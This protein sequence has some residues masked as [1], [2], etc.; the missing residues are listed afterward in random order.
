M[1]ARRANRVPTAC[2][3]MALDKHSVLI[4]RAHCMVRQVLP[5]TEA[6]E[7]VARVLRC[8]N[9]VLGKDHQ[10]EARLCGASAE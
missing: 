10:Y 1:V 5:A 3:N 6:C 9:L 8:K 4:G 7:H 2:Q